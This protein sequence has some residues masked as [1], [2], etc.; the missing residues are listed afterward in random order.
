MS[1]ELTTAAMQAAFP[2]LDGPGKAEAV[3]RRLVE[4]IR[5]G[6]LTDGQKLPS[7][8]ELAAQFAVSTVTLREALARLREAGM[9]ETRR[10][11]GGG[12]V[13]TAPVRLIGAGLEQ[14]LGDLTV[15]ELRELGDHRA[16]IAGAS[17]ALAA[18]RAGQQEMDRL[19]LHIERLESASTISDRRRADDGFHIEIAAA[20][21]SSRLTRAEI[22]LQSEIGDVLWLS[23]D[24]ERRATEAASF[25]RRIFA[26]IG[27]RKG[28]Q[29]RA[30]TEAHI[31]EEMADLI[32]F[33]LTLRRLS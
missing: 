28:A 20:A 15:Q 1:G 17:A 10:G 8:S 32:R 11:R 18:E 14:W 12:T 31:A 9:V 7:E 2:P 24:Q 22:A 3:F 19:H 13:V 30:V 6:L 5:L 16:A 33:R 4:A 23:T 27:K 21:Q 29:A 26:A 25:H